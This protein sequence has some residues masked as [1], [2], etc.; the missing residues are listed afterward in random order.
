VCGFYFKKERSNKIIRGEDSRPFGQR[1][2]ELH[3][4]SI[5]K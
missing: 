2:E 4:M 1:K 3:F 5:Q